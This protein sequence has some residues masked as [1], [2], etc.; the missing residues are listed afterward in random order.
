MSAGPDGG[1]AAVPGALDSLGQRFVAT[2]SPFS[3]LLEREIV[4]YLKIWYYSLLGPIS[5]ALLLLLVFGLA[6]DHRVTIGHGVPYDR[7]VMPGLMGQAV[8]T[9]CYFN[10]CTSL[11]EARRDRYMNDVLASPLR[12]WEINAAVVLAGISR[13]LLTAAGVAAVAVPVTGASVHDPVVL[14]LGLVGALIVAAQFGVI[15][16]IHVRTMDHVAL[17][18]NLLVQP[19]TFLGGSFYAVSALPHAWRVVTE[20]N[21]MFYVVQALRI[22]FLGSGDVKAWVALAVLWAIAL[23]LT[24]FSL[25]LFHSGRRLKD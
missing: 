12:W 22:G 3:W 17:I 21:P 23:V 13:G 9:A 15:A 20:L 16:G 10:G 18:Q 8:L 4:R 25:S 5:A 7:F 2:R 14:V 24:A 6:L 19:V 11:F 1:A